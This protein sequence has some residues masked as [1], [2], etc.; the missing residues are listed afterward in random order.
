[1]QGILKAGPHNIN[2]KQLTVVPITSYLFIGVSTRVLSTLV[3][4]SYPTEDSEIIGTQRPR[5]CFLTL[6]RML[7]EKKQPT[8]P[9]QKNTD[10]KVKA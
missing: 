7:T 4:H 8:T 6:N 2:P 10:F 9:Q 3:G 5:P 1:M